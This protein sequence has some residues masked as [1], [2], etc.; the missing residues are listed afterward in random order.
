M[1][2]GEKKENRDL[3]A[4]CCFPHRVASLC[5]TAMPSPGIH[6]TAMYNS[7]AASIMYDTTPLSLHL[8]VSQSQSVGSV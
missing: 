6:I 3:V 2:Q 4:Q 7:A 5:P 1:Y 8:R